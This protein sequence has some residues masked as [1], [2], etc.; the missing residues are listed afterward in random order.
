M[1]GENVVLLVPVVIPLLYAHITAL[2]SLVPSSISVK[3]FVPSAFGLPA[4]FH[5]IITIWLREMEEFGLNL[6]PELMMPL[7]SA[8]RIA[9]VVFLPLISENGF[10]PPTTGLPCIFHSII[11]NWTFVQLPLG[12]N[13]VSDV[14][15]T[16]LLLYAQEIYL[17]A[18][19]FDSTSVN[20]LKTI[21]S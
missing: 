11:T 17:K 4:S 21:V 18:L 14:P 12:V 5:R 7:S 9:F 8:H 6:L 2:H 19:P 13:V 16:M 15:V 1:S 3:G 20:G 10:S